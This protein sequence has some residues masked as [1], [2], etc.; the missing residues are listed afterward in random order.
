[1]RG[2]QLLEKGND[3]ATTSEDRVQRE[4]L[5]ISS[6]EREP[7]WKHKTLCKVTCCSQPMDKTQQLEIRPSYDAETLTTAHGPDAIYPTMLTR[8]IRNSRAP[9]K[10]PMPNQ[11]KLHR[12]EDGLA[13]KATMTTDADMLFKPTMK[14]DLKSPAGKTMLVHIA[15]IRELLQLELPELIQQRDARDSV[16]NGHT[17]DSI[18]RKMLWQLTRGRQP[19]VHAFKVFSTV[20]WKG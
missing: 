6:R 5:W 4:I 17:K 13:L 9:M 15:L 1:M 8:M 10:A 2:L 19:Y 3:L 14:H 12:G 7:L 11:L 16:A 18:D 20:S